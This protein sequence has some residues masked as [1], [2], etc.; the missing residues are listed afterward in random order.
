MTDK[1]DPSRPFDKEVAYKIELGDGI[2][3]MRTIAQARQALNT[4]GL[5]I[6]HEED[7]AA[8]PDAIA[9]YPLVNYASVTNLNC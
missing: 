2:A 8:R 1:W 9:S 4:V 5:E 6:L 7:L 3:E